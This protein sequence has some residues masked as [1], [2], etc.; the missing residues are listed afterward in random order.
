MWVTTRLL[1]D[2][3][4]QPIVYD[5]KVDQ[6]HARSLSRLETQDIKTQPSIN[7]DLISFGNE[8]HGW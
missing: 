3:A 7:H 4:D 5:L 1:R 2:L 8:I 6:L